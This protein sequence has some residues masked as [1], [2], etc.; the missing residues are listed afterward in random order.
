MP[1]LMVLRHAAMHA[2]I[3]A[4]VPRLMVLRHAVMHACIQAIM[5]WLMVLRHAVMHACIQAVMPWL[6]VLR[7]AVMHAVVLWP[8]V[9]VSDLACI[10]AV[11][12]GQWWIV[13]HLAVR[14]VMHDLEM[15]SSRHEP[16]SLR[17]PAHDPRRSDAPPQD[18]PHL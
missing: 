6:T 1:W 3:Q 7:H 2:C 9:L 11:A 15:P 12:C 18:F 17:L 13:M 10:E 16:R 5:P 8:V 14:L 4:V